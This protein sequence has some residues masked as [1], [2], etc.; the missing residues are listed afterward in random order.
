MNPKV[1]VEVGVGSEGCSTELF[2]TLC[3]HGVAGHL[4]SVDIDPEKTRPAVERICKRGLDKYWT[5]TVS[6]A[7]EFAKGFDETIDLF[8][9]DIFHENPELISEEY[10]FRVFEAY[11]QLMAKNG[12]MAINNTCFAK[13]CRTGLIKF[14]EETDWQCSF[15]RKGIGIA[16]CKVVKP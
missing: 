6:D 1:I 14:T 9:I 16:I 11:G 4:W 2:L 10:H 5:F 15:L 12:I 8:Y 7:L 3:K 13:G